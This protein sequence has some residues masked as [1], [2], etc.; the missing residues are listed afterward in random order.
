MSVIQIENRGRLRILTIN[1]I[2]K[3]NALNRQGYLDLT[4]ALLDADKDDTVSVLAITGAGNFYSSGNDIAGAFSDPVPEEER[5]AILTNLV[6]AFY[7]FSK[8]LI[9]VVNGPCIGISATT[10][11][12]CDVI[13][14]EKD[15]YFYTPFT[16]LGLCAEGCSSVTF[17]RI[18]GK[19]KANEMLLLNHK[20]TAQEALQFNFVSEV[21]SMKDLNT[22]IWPRIEGFAKLP[23]KSIMTTKS[24]IKR[25]ETEEL[26]AANIVENEALGE[27]ITSEECIQAAMEFMQKK[28][29]SSL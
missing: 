1:N 24:L 7:T 18:L 21:F 17:P 27:R 28:M 25:F 16:S 26:E 12:L 22:K 23:Y 5:K 11:A 29:K 10:A 15:A 9:A 20:L 2:K 4:K 6:K 13:Y 14:A 19:S 8:L 3:R